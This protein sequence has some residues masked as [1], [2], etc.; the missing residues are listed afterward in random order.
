MVR[1]SRL[2]DRQRADLTV[3]QCVAPNLQLVEL[4]VKLLMPRKVGVATSLAEFQGLV[5]VQ[6]TAVG[7]GHGQSPVDIKL[8]RPSGTVHFAGID[9]VGPGVGGDVVRTARA[10]TFARAGST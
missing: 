1:V 2:P 3:A 5:G 8:V 7:F 4:T 9:Q 10:A 6:Y